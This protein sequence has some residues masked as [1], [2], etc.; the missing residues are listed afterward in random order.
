MKIIGKIQ[1]GIFSALIVG[2]SIFFFRGLIFESDP[3]RFP[4]PGITVISQAYEGK[5]SGV[6]A[7]VKGEVTRV[8]MDGVEP[9]NQ[10][11]VMQLLDGRA[12]LVEHKFG[13]SERIPLAVG[14]SV[15]VKGVYYWSEPGGILRWT[16][17]DDRVSGEDGWIEHKGQRYD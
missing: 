4:E 15:T 14:D 1:A 12:L 6:P 11:F 16:Y 7:K 3:G 9:G 10:K 8:L 2:I 17:E 13:K 5:Q